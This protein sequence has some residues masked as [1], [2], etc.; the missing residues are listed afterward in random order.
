[1]RN[2]LQEKRK[3]RQTHQMLLHQEIRRKK[4]TPKSPKNAPS[5]HNKQK[6]TQKNQKI[7]KKKR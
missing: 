3:D 6:K 4:S 2:T 5:N 7:K 1:V